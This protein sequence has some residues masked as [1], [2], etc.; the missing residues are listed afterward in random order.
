MKAAWYWIIRNSVRFWFFM[1]T[2]GFRV[3]DA[4]NVPKSGPLILAPNHSSFLDPPA[5]ACALPRMTT[6]M[7]KEELFRNKLFGWLISSVG[8]FPVRRG[9]TDMEA[10][11]NAAKLLESGSALL[12]FPEGTRNDGDTM[13]PINRGVELLARKSGASVVPV[14][15]VG[16]HIKWGKG[17]KRKL[18]QKVTVNFGEPI[19]PEDFGDSK[20]AFA[21]E[22]AK[23]IAGL[24]NEEGY[25][26]K[27][28][29]D[30]RPNIALAPDGGANEAPNQEPDSVAGPQ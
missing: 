10:I 1:L 3:V 17:R 19:R 6:F 18:F 11:R 23:R 20:A 7:A 30:T 16:T 15:I 22:L 24:C 29:P 4:K 14:G 12:I 21:E 9:T 28:A 27:I 8:S 2:G 13:L 25:D 5:L 26:L